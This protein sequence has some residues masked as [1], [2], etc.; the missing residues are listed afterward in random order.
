MVR[1]TFINAQMLIRETSLFTRRVTDLL[2][3]DEYRALQAELVANPGAGAVIR[4]SG[5][6]R[7]VRWALPGGGKSGGVRVIYFWQVSA[8]VILMLYIYPKNERDNLTDAQLAALRKVVE[9]EYP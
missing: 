9:A 5:G 6:I 3:D 4:K 7:K 8:S 2:S 1:C